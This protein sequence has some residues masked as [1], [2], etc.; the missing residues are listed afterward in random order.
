M[1]VEAQEG[2]DHYNPRFVIVDDDGKIIDDAQGYGYHSKST[3]SKA[4]WYK[5]KG[6]K[7]KLNQEK[8][9]RNDFF[10]K[11]KGLKKFLNRIY[12]TNFKEIARGEV[13][14]QDI[15]DEIKEKF[16]IDIPK[17]YLSID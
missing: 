16:N 14:D 8:K 1:R 7:T 6:G 9:D 11:N 10:Q 12:E 17:K 3:A 5:F 2:S 13:T 15:I 4:L